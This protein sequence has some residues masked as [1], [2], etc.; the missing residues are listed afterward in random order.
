[1]PLGPRG[2]LGETMRI[3]ISGYYGFGNSGDEA[4]LAALIAELQRRLPAAQLTVLSAAPQATTSQYG[5]AAVARWSPQ[6]VWRA[7]RG[8]E[9]LISG[10]GGLI[11][12]TTSALSPLYYLAILRLARLVGVPYMIFAQGIGPLRS[13]LVRRAT[14]RCFRRAAAITVRDEQSAQLLAELGLTAPQPEVTAD[15]AVL[16]A[17]CPPARTRRL[18][19]ERGLAP[20]TPVVGLALRSWPGT[21]VARPA[22]ALI[23][24][25]REAY[26]A[27]ALLIPFQPEQDLSLAWQVAGEAKG[28]ARILEP[29]VTPQEL[30]GVISRLDLLVS[31]RL[32]GLIFAAAAEVPALAVVYDPKVAAFAGRAGQP[33]MGL[34]DLEA[35]RL[36]GAVAQL[37]ESRAQG[38]GARH[39][40]AEDLRRAAARN[41]DI[42]AALLG[43]SASQAAR[44]VTRS[45]GGG[46]RRACS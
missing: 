38:S 2:T 13:H 18:L 14:A 11:Q 7:L 20:G 36:I 1:M 41:F 22:A 26:S 23:R 46:E 17:P 29:A 9:L 42:L 4:I 12:D 21:D 28:H 33:M 15:P 30:R 39:Q 32:H 8:A 27:Q 16:L 10:G 25:I 37:W 5:V 3:V 6:A 31:M 43:P 44:A 19:A 40:A 24:H 45:A 34:S 35:E